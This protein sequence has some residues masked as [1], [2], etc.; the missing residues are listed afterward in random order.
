MIEVVI[1]LHSLPTCES[2]SYYTCS[3]EPIA[4]DGAD[5]V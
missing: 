2:I 3:T 4:I 5:V 1:D